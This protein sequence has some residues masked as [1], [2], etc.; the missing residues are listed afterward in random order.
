[1]EGSTTLGSLPAGAELS[2]GE[3][4]VRSGVFTLPASG[5]TG[6]SKWAP[7]GAKWAPLAGLQRGGALEGATMGRQREGGQKMPAE[8]ANK[9]PQ[10]VC[11][12]QTQQASWGR[13]FGSGF[14]LSLAAVW[15]IIITI[16]KEV[17]SDG[18]NMQTV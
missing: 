11:A 4:L 17:P 5:T 14:S 2:G 3:R 18:A 9:A 12:G 10:S 6:G 13:P 16:N 1:M 7:L 8:R 15:R